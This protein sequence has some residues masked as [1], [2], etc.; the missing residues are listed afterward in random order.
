MRCWLLAIFATSREAASIW[1]SVF[2]RRSACNVEAVYVRPCVRQVGTDR[3]QAATNQ[4]RK[5]RFTQERAA[6]ATRARESSQAECM[7]TN[8][9]ELIVDQLAFQFC[10]GVCP[11]RDLHNHRLVAAH[12]HIGTRLCAL[13][14]PAYPG[15]AAALVLPHL[16]ERC[17]FAESCCRRLFHSIVKGKVLCLPL[18]ASRGDGGEVGA[19]SPH[20]RL[21]SRAA[22]LCDDNKLNGFKFRALSHSKRF[23][24]TRDLSAILKEGEVQ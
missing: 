2:A 1:S 5:G 20:A 15:P 10:G 21:S 16:Q 19:C 4:K 18:L 11:A 9:R 8:V 6:N 22:S 24:K 23:H 7:G 14:F 13:Y 17:E 3:Q 12:S